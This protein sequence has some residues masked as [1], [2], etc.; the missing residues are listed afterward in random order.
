VEHNIKVSISCITYNQVDYIRSCL[1]GFLMQKVNFKYEI[2]INDDASTDGTREV[3]EE[4]AQKHPDIIVPVLQTENQVSKGLRGMMIRFTFPL[5][6]GKYIA[7]CEGDDYWTDPYKLQKQVDFL[8]ANENY[9]MVF[10]DIDFYSEKLDKYTRAVFKNKVLP[11][12][13]TFKEVLIHKPY[14]APPTWV[15]R[16]EYIPSELHDYSDGSYTMILDILAVT[17]A[18]YLEEVTA[19]YRELQNSASHF[20]NSSKRY[21]RYKGLYRI[22]SDYCAKY[23]VSKEIKD[24]IDLKYYTMVFPYIL[25]YGGD[26][27]VKA[28]KEKL[29]P[30]TEVGRKLKL[31]LFTSNLPFGKYIYKKVFQV[32]DKYFPT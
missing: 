20:P 19:V 23:K 14:V 12:Y 27:E 22:Q 29:A 26:S 28:A 24:E 32:R 25:A 15:F 21:N 13:Y 16:R 8:D 1:D 4:Y 3:I 18:Y 17:K 6:K 7:F 31:A 10:S 9:G 2:V 30:L 5:C 11:L